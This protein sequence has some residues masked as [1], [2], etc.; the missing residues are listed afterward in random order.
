MGRELIQYSTGNIPIWPQIGSRAVA[1]FEADSNE[2]EK[3]PPAVA[4][5]S[6][7]ILLQ[8]LAMKIPWVHNILLIQMIKDPSV[9]LSVA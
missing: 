6:Q 8:Q 9:R 7:F 2:H 4:R 5:S 1:Q 3:R